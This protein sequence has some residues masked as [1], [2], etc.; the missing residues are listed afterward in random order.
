MPVLAAQPALVASN[1]IPARQTFSHSDITSRTCPPSA[2]F[3]A[4][5]AMQNATSADFPNVMGGYQKVSPEYQG[6][7]AVV[8]FRHPDHFVNLCAGSSPLFKTRGCSSLFEHTEMK[9]NEGFFIMQTKIE[10]GFA[11]KHG[12]EIERAL[13]G[14]SPGSGNCLALFWVHQ[15]SVHN[16][17]RVAPLAKGYYFWI[18]L[19]GFRTPYGCLRNG[20]HMFLR[21]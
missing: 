21:S 1:V 13:K 2:T 5:I 4:V 17:L 16:N 7:G 18:F 15:Y 8:F 12:K 11:M 10:R 3:C 20:G 19:R 9:G 14:K 6:A